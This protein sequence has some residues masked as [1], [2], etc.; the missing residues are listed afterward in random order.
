[1]RE[2]HR[3]FIDVHIVCAW[4]VTSVCDKYGIK[5]HFTLDNRLC[6]TVSFIKLQRGF[7]EQH[8][9]A[10]FSHSTPFI[11]NHCILGLPG[12]LFVFAV[13]VV[14]TTSSTRVYMFALAIADTAVCVS[15]I[16]LAM[17]YTDIVTVVILNE[18]INVTTVFA[19]FLLTFVSIER[20]LAIRRPHTFS[21]LP[22]RAKK[23]LGFIT[24]ST[25]IFEIL[26]WI[27]AFTGN[28]GVVDI[29]AAAVLLSC[30]TVMVTCYT[31]IAVSL[32]QKARASRVKTRVINRTDSSPQPGT[33]RKDHATTSTGVIS[34]LHIS[35]TTS[36]A[37][38]DTN[39]A[40]AAQA[41]NYRGVLLLFVITVVF[42]GSWLPLW[43]SNAGVS[44]PPHIRRLFLVNAVAN[45]YIYGFAS[46]MFREDVRNFFRQV[47]NWLTACCH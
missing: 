21:L 47:N 33:S 5:K 45:P 40:T 1:M 18:T 7:G 39:K 9:K 2:K 26:V 25:G 38:T 30:F 41:N 43:L 22:L 36:V 15:S 31:L 42:L 46:P 12:N 24:L 34:N 23:S 44:I 8:R 17:G 19:V 4:Y 37:V 27:F 14:K 6:T 32:M 3:H 10:T 35:V 16:V 28:I 20:F 11:I 13:Y 29:I